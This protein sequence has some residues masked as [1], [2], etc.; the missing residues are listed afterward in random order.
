MRLRRL[1]L[2]G[3]EPAPSERLRA[4]EWLANA[5]RHAGRKAP[6]AARRSRIRDVRLGAS[7][8]ASASARVASRP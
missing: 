1:P 4:R 6:P 3:S 7:S 8:L 2:K 5:L